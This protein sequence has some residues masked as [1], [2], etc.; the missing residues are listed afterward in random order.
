MPIQEVGTEQKPCPIRVRA[1]DSIEP[2]KPFK[3]T[4]KEPVKEVSREV[5]RLGRVDAAQVDRAEEDDRR[6]HAFRRWPR[7]SKS[8]DRST[9]LGISN[10]V[11]KIGLWSRSY[12][13]IKNNDLVATHLQNI[14]INCL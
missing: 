13:N 14:Y 1:L 11:G 9:T 6:M 4:A 3:N 5:D 8:V 12:K 2:G 10:S 7:S